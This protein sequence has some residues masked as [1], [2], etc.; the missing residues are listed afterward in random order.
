M[1]EH[2]VIGGVYRVYKGDV[3]VVG[4]AEV[5]VALIDIAVEAL[6]GAGFAVGVGGVGVEV[7]FE[8]GVACGVGEGRRG[9]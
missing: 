6:L 9:W 1:D 2:E 5:V 3:M 8:P 4:E 7:A